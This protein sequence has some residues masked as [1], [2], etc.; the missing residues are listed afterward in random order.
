MYRLTTQLEVLL[1]AAAINLGQS[2]W[3][4]ACLVATAANFYLTTWEEYHTKV[5]C[6]LGVH[7]CVGVRHVAA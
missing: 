4:V 5:R 2:W 1:T 3:T 6:E 7:P